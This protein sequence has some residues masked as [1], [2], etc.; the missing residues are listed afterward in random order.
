M[1]IWPVPHPDIGGGINMTEE[2]RQA[3]A[4]RSRCEFVLVVDAVEDVGIAAEQMC[5]PSGQWPKVP[6]P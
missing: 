1:P 6:D 4:A 2:E 5:D 3:L